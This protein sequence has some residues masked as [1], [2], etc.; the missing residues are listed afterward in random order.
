MNKVCEANGFKCNVPLSKT[1]RI[2]WHMLFQNSKCQP[3]HSNVILASF[4]KQ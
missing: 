2:L 3:A 1:Y 4:L